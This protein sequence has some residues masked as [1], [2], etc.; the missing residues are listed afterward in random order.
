MRR[1]VAEYDARPKPFSLG[2]GISWTLIWAAI[3][4]T[5]KW[6]IV[7]YYGFETHQDNSRAAFLDFTF[8]LLPAL[9][10]HLEGSGEAGRWLL[11]A[12]AFFA[13]GLFLWFLKNGETRSPAWLMASLAGGAL[14]NLVDRLWYGAVVDFISLHWAGFLLVCFQSAMCGLRSVSAFCCYKFCKMLR[15][16]KRVIRHRQVRFALVGLSAI[17]KTLKYEDHGEHEIQNRIFGGL[18]PE[19]NSL[20]RQ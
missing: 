2:H 11:S 13:I 14:G 9:A 20:W 7:H 4:Q 16:H 19:L 3:D 8:D 1:A 12:I 17:D 6:A 18:D 15:S 10:T 5:S